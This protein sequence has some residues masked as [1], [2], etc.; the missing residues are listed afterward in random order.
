MVVKVTVVAGSKLM[1]SQG[2]RCNPYCSIW[3]GSVRKQTHVLSDTLNP[4]WSE[5]FTFEWT[6]AHEGQTSVIVLTVFNRINSR[7][8]CV[9]TVDLDLF[10]IVE[11][12]GVVDDWFELRLPPNGTKR[13]GL[14]RDGA[15]VGGSIK[16]KV[17][18]SSPA[19]T[20]RVDS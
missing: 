3:L 18:I 16:L 10:K 13:D 17:G 7:D 14:R 15:D 11:S 8:T 5:T 2:L 9:G 20:K 6:N 1:S 12:G 19:N 4:H